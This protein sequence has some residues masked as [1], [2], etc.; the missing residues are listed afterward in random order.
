MRILI[1]GIS[2]F[3][4]G[5]IAEHLVKQG[6]DVVGLSRSPYK[7]SN[8][9]KTLQA[10][11]ANITFI[12]QVLEK[13]SYCDVIIHAAAV[14]NNNL[15]VPEISL[16][17]CLGT[18]QMLHLAHIWKIKKFIYLSSVPV[19]GK[20]KELPITER[21]PVDPLTAYHASKLYGESLVK[22]SSNNSEFKSVILRLTSPIG[23]GMQDNRILSL[24]V[25]KALCNSPITILG[26]G[27]RQQNYV[28]VRDLSLAVRSCVEF[29]NAEG[30]FNIGGEKS[31]SNLEL[32]ST[33]I[34]TLKSSS[35]IIFS[36][37]H[38]IEEGVNW[39]VS[40]NKAKKFLNYR[41]QYTIENSISEIGDSFARCNY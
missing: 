33:C 12:D 35:Q 6:Y 14:I 37:D 5:A 32:A 11:I 16:T 36:E 20:P 3:V 26:Q 25:R 40:I 34:K 27:A 17:N 23:K 30:M 29:N 28:D 15:Y 22:I 13:I 39:N 10:D 19:I 9:V 18:Q 8:L 24:F 41:P 1:T 31:I 38:D 2:G 21:H 4:G 7:N